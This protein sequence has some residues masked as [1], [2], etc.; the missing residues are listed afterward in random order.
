MATPV[1]PN[2]RADLEEDLIAS[3]GRA[4]CPFCGAKVSPSDFAPVESFDEALR[5]APAQRE[6][7]VVVPKVVE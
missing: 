3:T 4:E 5:N 1:C 7:M 6:K 2:C